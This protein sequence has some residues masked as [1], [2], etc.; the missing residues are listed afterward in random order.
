MIHRRLT[1]P[2]DARARRCVLTLEDGQAV[3]IA[4]LPDYLLADPSFPVGAVAQYELT[5]DGDRL[6]FEWSVYASA[7]Q[8]APDLVR[9]WVDL[10]ALADRAALMVL[11]SQATIRVQC[12]TIG[13]PD[14]VLAT[15][16]LPN[17]DAAAQML[18]R[19]LL[20]ES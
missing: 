8:H 14:Q 2:L 6:C 1:P 10:N 16:T 18:W 4:L 19:W 12:V 5:R 17:P 11:A 15:L 7:V 9:A 20:A 3:F 13:A